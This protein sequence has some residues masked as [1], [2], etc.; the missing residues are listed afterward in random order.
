MF[1][2]VSAI[3][4][5]WCILCSVSLAESSAPLRPDDFVQAVLGQH[6][7]IRKVKHQVEAARF[8]LKASGL[9]PNPS[10]TLAATLGDAGESANALSQQFEISGQPGIRK[11]MAQA[12]L[13]QA[14]FQEKATIKDI[15]ILA[16][17]LWVRL[18][19]TQRL[20]ELA[21]LR[22]LLLSDMG[23]VALRRFEVG[24]ISENESLR[25]DLA[26]AAAKAQKNQVEASAQAALAE[27]S[28]LLGDM[29]YPGDLANPQE[30]ES[31]LSSTNLEE[32]LSEAGEHPAVRSLRSRYVAIQSK[33]ELI[34]KERAPALNFSVYRS[35]LFQTSTVEQGV[36]LSMTWPI[37][38][39]GSITH[40]RN[41]QEKTAE[42][43]LDS[44]EE[45]LLSNRQSL[46]QT[47]ANLEAAR[48]NREVLS[49]QASR[50]EEL[51]REAR[52]AYDVGLLGLADVLQTE[53]AFRQAGVDLI[54]AK[55]SVLNLELKVLSL[56][57]IPLPPS[58]SQ[59]TVHE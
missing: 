41:Q 36:Q 45:R 53:Q 29:A 35:R 42:A 18:W 59:E 32:V 1:F 17:L 13:S 31:L 50:Y 51:A 34:G 3:F 2:R 58:F 26:V 28:L 38:D 14:E 57:N 24:E 52:I 25:V 40:R 27:A 21:E 4:L 44:I 9:Q 39:W 48:K 7:S 6:P 20:S 16:L 56:T 30:P 10:L 37:F 54:E 55:A 11:R 23:R 46:V 33:A 43:F 22:Y 49:V 5:L 47:W 8:G 12:I 19:K 15:K